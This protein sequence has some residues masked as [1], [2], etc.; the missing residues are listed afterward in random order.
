M[1]VRYILF[2]TIAYLLF[3]CSP[4][5]STQPSLNNKEKH[6][7]TVEDATQ[8][9]LKGLSPE[10]REHLRALSKEKLITLLNSMGMTIQ[11]K[12]G[13]TEANDTL[14]INACQR[15]CSPEEA[16]MKILEAAWT[17]LQE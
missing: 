4:A 17:K 11:E 10:E 7:P 16:S 14:T 6:I 8:D 12:Y 2:V 9:F 15:M 13:L 1:H 3:G 5:D